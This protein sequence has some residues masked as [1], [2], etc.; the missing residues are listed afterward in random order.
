MSFENHLSSEQVKNMITEKRHL[1]DKVNEK[2]LTRQ[3]SI[4][5]KRKAIKQIA[6]MINGK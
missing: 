5:E 3:Y 1:C 2:E 6:Q 4:Q